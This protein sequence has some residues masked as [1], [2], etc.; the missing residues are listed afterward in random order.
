DRS[1]SADASPAM[2]VRRN[3]AI[4]IYRDPHQERVKIANGR[5]RQITDWHAVVRDRHSPVIRKFA[6]HSCIR[7]ELTLF[8]QVEEGADSG[9]QQLLEFRPCLC[10]SWR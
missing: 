5:H 4:D 1:R 2:D 6:E 3:A 9:V 7:R 10:V 8:G